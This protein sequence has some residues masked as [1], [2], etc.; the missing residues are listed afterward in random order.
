M[1]VSGSVS[2]PRCD[3]IDL[4]NG[5]LLDGR[6]IYAQPRRGFRS[7][8]EP[9][10][11][12]ASVPARGGERILE[13]GTG[14]GATLLCLVTRVAGLQA[15]G[16]ERDRGL[17]SLAQRNAAANAPAGLSF[18]EGDMAALPEI[19]MFDHACA[20]PPYHAAAGSPSPN[21]ERDAAKRGGAGVIQLWA[22]ALASRLRPRGTLTFILPAAMLTVGIAAFASANCPASAMLPLWARRASPAKLVLLRGVRGRRSP[23]RVLPGLVL[24]DDGGK[25]T[26]DAEKILRDGRALPL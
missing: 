25:F 14:A 12:A 4:T 8:I 20:N 16:V 3:D 5:H 23:F 7:G 2:D 24:H 17:V 13:G 18:I 15:V 10:L 6:V 19:G 26:Q 11:L 9:V 21:P 22:A 1:G